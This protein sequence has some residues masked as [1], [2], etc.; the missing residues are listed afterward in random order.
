MDS[1]LFRIL[2][3]AAGSGS[4]LDSGSKVI[5]AYLVAASSIG[6]KS[7]KVDS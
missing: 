5:A 7:R 3:T 6:V 1:I 2:C 4:G